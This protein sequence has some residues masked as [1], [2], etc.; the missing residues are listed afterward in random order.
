MILL[1]SGR[2]SGHD[3]KPYWKV[4]YTTRGHRPGRKGKSPSNGVRVD[5]GTVKAPPVL[6]VGWGEE[7]EK[8]DPN[9]MIKLF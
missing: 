6:R 4:C 8:T 3:K 1:E 7:T 5:R 2:S 9:L